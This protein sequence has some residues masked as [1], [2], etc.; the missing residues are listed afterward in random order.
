[1][2]LTG[3]SVKSLVHAFAAATSHRT[4]YC[5]ALA[6]GPAVSGADRP[7]AMTVTGATSRTAMTGVAETPDTAKRTLIYGEL[8]RFNAASAADTGEL[9]MVGR[10]KETI[11]LS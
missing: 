5:L 7:Y 8:T 9:A 6:H 3:K 1:A 10:W 11:E 4:P 2:L